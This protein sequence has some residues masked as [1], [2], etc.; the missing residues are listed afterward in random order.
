[1]LG[2]AVTSVVPVIVIG[3]DVSVHG[4]KHSGSDP[5]AISVHLDN[6]FDRLTF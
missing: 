2:F 4:R 5:G 6:H 1:M 3:V